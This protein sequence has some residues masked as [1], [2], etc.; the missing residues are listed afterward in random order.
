MKPYLLT[1]LLFLVIETPAREGMWLPQLLKELNESE[2]KS[3]GMEISADDIYSINH[4]S[5][6]DAVLKFGSGC[7]GELISSKGLLITNHHCGFSQI[8]AAST[9][10]KNYLKEGFWA[11]NN[12]EEIPFPGLTVTF[13][14]EISDV[15]SAILSGI[16]DTMSENSRNNFIKIRTDSI[17]KTIDGN[18]KANIRQFYQGNKFYLFITEIF[19]D[20]RFVGAPPQSIGKFGGET[21]NWMWPRHSG[22][23]SLFRIYS[24]KENKSAAYSKE[25]IPYTPEQF[26]TI[27]IG[28]VKEND[29]VF[30]FGFP[31]RT[32]QYLPSSA[33]EIISTQTN[34]NRIAIRKARLDVMREEMNESEI[35]QLQY[36]AK[37]S[38]LENYYKKWQGE[39]LGFRRF[40]VIEKKKI[41]EKKFISD[42][43]NY[44]KLNDDATLFYYYDKLVEESKPL[45][46]VNDF[47]SEAFPGIELINASARFKKLVELCSDQNQEEKIIQDEVIKI[48]KDFRIFYKNY[49]SSLD[50]RICSA[51]L[52]LS[53]SK[54]DKQYLPKIILDESNRNEKFVNYSEW[55]FK[56]S[57]VSDSSRLMKLFSTFKRA[58]V[59]KILSDPAYKLSLNFAEIQSKLQVDLAGMNAQI[60]RLQRKYMRD[61]L[62]IDKTG[63]L[64]PDANSTLR[65]S[66]GKVKGVNARDGLNYNYFST[67]AGILE[68]SESNV[69]DYN[70]PPK[71]S[72]LLK[73]KDFGRYGSEGKLPVAFLSSV[74]TTNGSSGSPTLNS[75]GELIGVNYDRI[76]EGVVSDYYYEEEY[77]RNISLDIRYVL[78]V[79]EKYGNAGWLINEMRIV[80]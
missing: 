40:N 52:S 61:L 46:F 54:L 7:T 75:K 14:R 1:L 23:F 25:N 62:A 79:I 74:H 3:M 12:E 27:S 66:Y 4:S 48:S 55:L 56:N 33:L 60:A 20:I 77:G 73:G 13:I 49:N 11:L 15:T 63:K 64:F 39:V 69:S 43:K 50:R 47:Y 72:S 31:G 59:R 18:L 44:P 41:E 37:T 35:V 67:T 17:E 2:M 71:F 16:S 76:W 10:E 57:L 53:Y 19:V 42:L 29:F 8:Q 32:S 78:F 9:I 80:D 22:D 5:L 34:P 58:D 51:V 28:G 38:S 30:V 21:D 36:S 65:I 26:L 45:N 68:K 24:N 70:I 6:K